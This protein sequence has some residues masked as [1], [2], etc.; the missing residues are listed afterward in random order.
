MR[1]LLKRRSIELIVADPDTPLE[2]R[3]LLRLVLEARDFAAE[4]LELKAAETYTTYANVGRDTLLLVLSASPGDALIPYTWSY[5]VAGRVAYKGFFSTDAARREAADLEARGYDTYLRPAGAFSTLGWFN[6]PLLSTALTGDSVSLAATVIHEIAHNTLYVPGATSFNE[7]FASFVGYRGAQ[8]LFE[9]LGDSANAAR[10]GG[11]WHDEMLLADFY[12]WLAGVLN[13]LYQSGSTDEALTRERTRI[14]G[15]ARERLQT[16]LGDSLQIYRADLLA[17]RTL[18][19]ASVVASRL[20]RTRL[21][22]FDALW[23]EAG[24][25]L[26]SAVKRLADA[27]QRDQEPAPLVVLQAISS[28]RPD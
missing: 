4:G 18:N 25:D 23:S 22:L 3:A 12:E 6:D 17:R 1:I 28:G 21:D 14:F 7:S 16:S 2:S 20:Y 5:P 8:A 19:N 10:A 11:I 26:R 15:M 13:R 27:I 9:S 24:G